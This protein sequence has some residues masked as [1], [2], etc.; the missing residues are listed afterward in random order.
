MRVERKVYE[1]RFKAI[2]HFVTYTT[3]DVP[4]DDDFF[5]SLT[6]MAYELPSDDDFFSFGHLY[7]L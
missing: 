2:S 3:Y 1:G 5:H 7:S 6:Y 4:N